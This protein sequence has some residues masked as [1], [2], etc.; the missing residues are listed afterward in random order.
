[1]KITA[2]ILFYLLNRYGDMQH[3]CHGADRMKLRRFEH[4]RNQK[5]TEAGVLYIYA[6]KKGVLLFCGGKK[7]KPAYI[8]MKALK[9]SNE[10]FS[11]LWIAYDNLDED[12]ERNSHLADEVSEYVGQIWNFFTQ[13][14]ND[15]L[16]AILNQ[17]TIEEVMKRCRGLLREPFGIVDRDMLM[18]Y[19][20]PELPDYLTDMFGEDY[21]RKVEEDLLVS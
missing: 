8:L 11:S 21:S 5:E 19:Q 13:I 15:I 10:D 16:E 20:Q 4:F 14:Q 1:M 17:E 18:L 2:G 12:V 6:D 9:E 3:I 7:Y